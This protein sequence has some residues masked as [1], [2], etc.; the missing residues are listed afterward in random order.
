MTTIEPALLLTKN[1]AL[2]TKP[3]RGRRRPSRDFSP[4]DRTR[5]L[6]FARPRL[7]HSFV[8]QK[9]ETLRHS[10][11]LSFNVSNNDTHLLK[12]VGRLRWTKQ[13][14]V[15]AQFIK[16][17]DGS[18]TATA[19]EIGSSSKKILASLQ[20]KTTLIFTGHRWGVRVCGRA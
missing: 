15:S 9:P 12:V 4:K 10:F 8:R 13:L 16:D 14:I 2:L 5:H 17:L 18:H 19:E 3:A 7:C 6:S 1:P 20:V 11:R